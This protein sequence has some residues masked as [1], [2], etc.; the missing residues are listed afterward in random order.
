MKPPMRRSLMTELYVEYVSGV[1]LL[2]PSHS[3]PPRVY[4]MVS[5]FVEISPRSALPGPS[6]AAEPPGLVVVLDAPGFGSSD[7]P[8][9]LSTSAPDARSASGAA[10]FL[11][12]NVPPR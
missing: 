10:N 6:G 1:L 8:H 5:S 3:S 9:A 11:I 4:E 12:F 2:Y 7:V